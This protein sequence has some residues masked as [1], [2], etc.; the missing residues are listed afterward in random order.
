MFKAV[1]LLLA[2]ISIFQTAVAI[3]FH[4][5]AVK[6]EPVVAVSFQAA[7]AI[8][9]ENRTQTEIKKFIK[10]YLILFILFLIMKYI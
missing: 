5:D 7:Y 6:E 2:V 4:I 10:I 3:S 8:N 1:L 9:T